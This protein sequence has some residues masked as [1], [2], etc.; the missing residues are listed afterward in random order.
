MAD[1]YNP[2]LLAW[3]RWLLGRSPTPKLLIRGYDVGKKLHRRAAASPQVF[4]NVGADP[5]MMDMC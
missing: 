2:H 4:L 1:E 5:V 3:W